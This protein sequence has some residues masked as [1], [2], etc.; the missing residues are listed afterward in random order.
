MQNN[1]FEYY[2]D[3]FAKIVHD[4]DFRR[5]GKAFKTDSKYYYYDT[6]TGKIFECTEE[7]FNVISTLQ[8]NNSFDALMK[9]PIEKDLLLEALGE[10]KETVE[11]Q[12][13]F[14]APVIETFSGEQVN[15]LERSLNT[16]L[17]Q[18]TFEVTQK[19]NLRCDYCIYQEENPKFRGFS[20]K[21]GMNFEI[22][23][24]VIDYASDKMNDDFYITFYGGEP[25]LNYGLI[26]QCVEYVEAC[27]FK[28][29]IRYSMTTNLTLMTKEKADF[30]ASVPN[31]TIVC[32][33]DGGQDIHDEHRKTVTGEGSFRYGME[34]LKNLRNAYKGKDEHIIF[35]MVLTPPYTREK[36]NKI[37][38]F[39]ADCPYI[40]DTSTIMY[41]Y[42]DDG[43]APEPEELK[44]RQA[45]E[46]EIL[47]MEEY[48]PV[49][50]WTI[51]NLLNTESPN[52][53]FTWSNF[54]KGLLKIHKRRL[55]DTPM[56]KCSF[57]GCCIPGGRRLYVTAT[58]DFHICE[59][60]GE[61]PEI[62]NIHDGININRIKE[63]YIDEYIEKS[64]EK[65]RKCW[66]VHL[67]GIC[68]ATCYNHEGLHM[69]TKDLR[70]ISEKF[71]I[72]NYL[73]QYHQ[74]YEKKPELLRPLNS[75]EL[76]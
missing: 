27:R 2:A 68:Y 63:K 36:F 67:C 60:I 39:I 24:K 19:C 37:Q 35:N 64:I 65:C 41:S 25:L 76:T 11:K 45:L 71:A 17:N 34:G 73:V 49:M 56:K 72:E 4:G 66:A 52:E 13:L 8:K 70:C 18:V 50:C 26:K 23:K 47:F 61:T 22:I 29:N 12:N 5:V 40:F 7:L 43:K 46:D 9:L 69:Q 51:E 42:A 53:L 31:F 14:Q 16:R 10:L 32:S 62:G 30:F 38:S 57:N 75:M 15:H 44:A 6:G 20:D 54:L 3:Y 74:L 33:I 1:S 55:S 59:R 48:N 58:G 21:K 28:N